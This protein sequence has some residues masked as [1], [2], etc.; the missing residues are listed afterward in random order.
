MSVLNGLFL[1]FPLLMEGD[2]HTHFTLILQ[3]TEPV[4]RALVLAKTTNP[5]HPLRKYK[6]RKIV[7]PPPPLEKKILSLITKAV[8]RD[9]TLFD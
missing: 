3:S 8:D 5:H 1:A 9:L 2:S 7:P 4:T 6:K